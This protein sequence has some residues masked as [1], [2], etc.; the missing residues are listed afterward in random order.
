MVPQSSVQTLS[1]LFPHAKRSV[2]QL[3]LQRCGQD[4]LKAIEYFNKNTSEFAAPSAFHPPEVQ[5][6]E[7]TNVTEASVNF[8]L[9]GSNIHR[10]AQCL[11]N[12]NFQRTQRASDQ[13][14]VLNLQYEREY[15]YSPQHYVSVD[16]LSRY[17]GILHLPSFIPGIS[18]VQPNC[19]FCCKFN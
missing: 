13:K 14:S 17:P 6:S 2:L 3:I 16:H 1:R 12:D 9:C 7:P 10:D 15:F 5:V 4:L 8:G 11:L 18:C 19:M